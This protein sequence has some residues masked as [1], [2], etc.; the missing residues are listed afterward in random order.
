MIAVAYQFLDEVVVGSPNRRGSF[1]I[2]LSPGLVYLHNLAGCNQFD[3]D[4]VGPNCLMQ[5]EIYY[6]A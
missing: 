4:D 3:K 5:T 1:L 2:G 6:L